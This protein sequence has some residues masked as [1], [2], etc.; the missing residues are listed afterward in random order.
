MNCVTELENWRSPVFY[1][2]EVHRVQLPF[3]GRAV[4]VCMSAEERNERKAQQL[5]RLQ[6]INSRRRE[7][8]LQEDQKR[9]ETLLSVQVHTL[10][11]RE[12]KRCAPPAHSDCPVPIRSCWRTDLWSCSTGVWWS[13]TW[14]RLRS[15][16]RTSI[17]SA[18]VWSSTGSWR[19]R[20]VHT[21][22]NINRINKT[23]FQWSASVKS[24]S[25]S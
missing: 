2:R 9:L 17:N 3:S 14:T 23:W 18:W 1:E 12:G 8:K 13:S 25:Y 24:L 21:D 10:T 15:F 4:G 5:R 19:P 7:E 6:E 16:S 20:F 11:R 22:N